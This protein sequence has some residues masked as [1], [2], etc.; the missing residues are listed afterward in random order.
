MFFHD[1]T[2]FFILICGALIRTHRDGP[3]S[4]QEVVRDVYYAK[5]YGKGGGE[6]PAGKKIKIMS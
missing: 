2:H 5:Y 4:R 3:W 6:C 1:M